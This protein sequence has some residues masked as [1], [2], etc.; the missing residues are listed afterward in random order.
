MISLESQ[1]DT[2]VNIY[3]IVSNEYNSENDCNEDM[4]HAYNVSKYIY[5]YV[6]INIYFFF[7]A[8]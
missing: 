3:F 6:Y 1:I 4:W 7:F 5:I 8:K 2:D